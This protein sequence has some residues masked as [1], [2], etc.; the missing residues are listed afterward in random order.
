MGP[1][2]LC[3]SG[4]AVAFAIGFASPA[5]AASAVLDME[6]GELDPGDFA[7]IEATARAELS[8][9][10]GG[11]LNVLIACGPR[12]TTVRVRSGLGPPVEREV[13]GV[14][15]EGP[16]LDELLAALHAL[17]A[18]ARLARRDAEPL[19]PEDMPPPDPPRHLA[20]S[21]RRADYRLAV[22][23]G[24][25]GEMWSGAFGP[26]F[27]PRAGARVA[28]NS[29][30]SLELDGGFLS[31]LQSTQGLNASSV[32]ATVRVDF[33]LPY[34]FRIG[35]AGDVRLVMAVASPGASPGQQTG[36]TMGAIMLARYTVR[37][38]RFEVS[39]G[40]QAEL[41]GRPIVIVADGLEAFRLPTLTA[42]LSIEAVAEIGE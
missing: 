3:L 13:A 36:T 8:E 9:A 25:D 14:L 28:R 31:G 12:A 33:P 10:G 17:I 20:S 42:G 15:D 23:A 22:V 18:E 19:D 37:V 4:S 29:D 27:G 35:F 30:W 16:S 26:A 32:Q 5:Q 40:P 41:F 34:H 11:D 7:A 38:D 21:P 2:R 6:C 24:L 1:G 39:V